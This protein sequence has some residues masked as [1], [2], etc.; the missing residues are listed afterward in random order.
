MSATDSLLTGPKRL[1]QYGLSALV[2]SS[3]C[4]LIYEPDLLFLGCFMI[5]FYLALSVLYEL[6]VCIKKGR[7]VIALFLALSPCCSVTLSTLSL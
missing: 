4:L 1:L 6:Y 3:L 2:A 7:Q 5:A